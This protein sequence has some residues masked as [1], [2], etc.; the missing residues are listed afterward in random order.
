METRI[1]D[2]ITKY[3]SRAPL[4]FHMP[5]HKGDK[6]YQALFSSAKI[7][8]TELDVI[9]NES[10]VR[11]AETDCKEILGVRHLRFLTGGATSGILSMVYAVKDFGNKLIISRYSH[12]SVYN[13]LKIC[14]I[15]PI[16]IDERGDSGV[17]LPPSVCDIEGALN[18]DGV[19]G[20][21]V[22][23]PDYYGNACD[24]KAISKAVK[25]ANKLLLVDNSHGGHYAFSKGLE[26][27][28][29]YADIA[30]DSA[31]KVFPTLNQGAYITCNDNKLSPL[32]DG[33]VE[34]FS[35]TSPSYVLLASVE[36]GIKYASENRGEFERLRLGVETL[37]Q[38]VKT[39]GFKI[40]EN[41]DFYKLSVDFDGS[42]ITAD[43]AQVYLEDKNLF[44]EMNDG[45]YL[46]FM[47]SVNTS[48]QDLEL[49]FAG[50]KELKDYIKNR[51]ANTRDMK[52]APR[53][54][55]YG[56]SHQKRVNYLDAL[57]G[58]SEIV[59][60]K[61]AVN[62]ISAVNAG[63]FPPCVPIVVAGEIITKEI[64]D[65]FNISQNKFGVENG[66]IAV[67]K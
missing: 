45:R 54:N 41:Q 27:A 65:I 66:E 19:I 43:M 6:D 51:G 56:V 39:L 10:V 53:R 37:K 63:V 2:A 47:F 9:D 52:F 32:V 28:G 57:K 50:L 18:K 12:K 64:I 61:D 20:V 8:V 22:T 44:L 1:L 29:R 42:G 24:I 21:L 13:A 4:R 58:E 26:Y 11:L 48:S 55:L 23:Y 59:L 15:E 33:A 25:N 46:L 62:R 40:I 14:N 34:L 3:S 31:H 38:K 67:L 49:L 5:A 35:T 30:V 16:I 7:D 17:P 60:L 36:Y